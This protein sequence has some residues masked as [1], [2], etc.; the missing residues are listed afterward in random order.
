M[1][2]KPTADQIKA[3]RRAGVLVRDLTIRTTWPAV[4]QATKRSASAVIRRWREAVGE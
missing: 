1:S 4:E 3:L 2:D